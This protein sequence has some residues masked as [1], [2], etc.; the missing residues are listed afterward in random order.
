MLGIWSKVIPTSTSFARARSM[1]DFYF[2]ISMKNIGM[3]ISF[4]FRFLYDSIFIQHRLFR[5][6]RIDLLCFLH[7]LIEHYVHVK[8]PIWW[9]G[10][11][12]CLVVGKRQDIVWQT[13]PFLFRE[14]LALFSIISY[15]DEPRLHKTFVSYLFWGFFWVLVA[16]VLCDL[17]LLLRHDH[18]S[19][20]LD[21][22]SYRSCCSFTLTSLSSLFPFF[23]SSLSFQVLSPY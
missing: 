15:Q 7:T 9:I 17:D 12:N 16:Q 8:C 11:F 1:F 3:K 2:F 22:F 5:V 14:S 6:C 4:F 18:I 21:E 20:C 13:P 10:A 23:P 19:H